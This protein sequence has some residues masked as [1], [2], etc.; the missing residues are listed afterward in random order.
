MRAT[1]R[2]CIQELIKRQ[3]HP[4]FVLA[5]ALTEMPELDQPADFNIA[6]VQGDA[7]QTLSP[8]LPVSAHPSGAGG[9][10]RYLF[11]IEWRIHLELSAFTQ[12]KL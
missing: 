5:V 10:T 12:S 7:S 8:T 4:V 6:Q 2:A 1:K 3:Q 11:R 9:D